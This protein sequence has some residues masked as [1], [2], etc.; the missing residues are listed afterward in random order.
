MDIDCLQEIHEGGVHLG[1]ESYGEDERKGE[2][3][4]EDEVSADVEI[5]GGQPGGVTVQTEARELTLPGLIQAEKD[6]TGE[7]EV[8]RP[9]EDGDGVVTVGRRAGVWLD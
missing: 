2:D 8:H 1:Q 3:E 5:R 6:E 7:D 4:S 9:R